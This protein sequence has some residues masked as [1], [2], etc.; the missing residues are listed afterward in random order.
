M[1]YTI[2]LVF[3]SLFSSSG[4][5]KVRNDTFDLIKED[6]RIMRILGSDIIAKQVTQ[7]VQFVD[8]HNNERLQIIYEVQGGKGSGRVDVEML[9]DGKE[10]R[11]QYVIVSTQY[12][13]I[14]IVDNRSLFDRA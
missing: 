12:T 5:D 10:W 13:V 3:K 9:K 14:P 4:A 8:D 7:N 2:Y 11:M 6:S 1:G